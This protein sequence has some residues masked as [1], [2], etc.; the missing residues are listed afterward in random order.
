MDK[1]RITAAVRKWLVIV[2]IFCIVAVISEILR[3]MGIGND[4]IILVFILGVFFSVICTGSYL[5]GFISAIIGVGLFNYLYTVPRYT[6]F[7]SKSA[8]VFLLCFFFIT[9]TSIGAIMSKLQKQKDEVEKA[10]RDIEKEQLR[11]ALLRSIAHDL[12]SPLTAMYGTSEL[13]ADDFDQ[14][15]D[16][17]KIE[18]THGIRDESVWL[19]NI[20]EN[21]LRMTRI[22]ES[23][24]TVNKE[25]E[26]IDDIVETAVTHMKSLLGKREFSV[27]LP[28]EIVSV[29]VDGQLIA[30]V[31]INL[32]DNAV[33]YT[34]PGDHISLD[35]TCG[36]NEAFFSVSDDGKAIDKSVKENIFDSFITTAGENGDKCSGSGLGL[37]I[38]RTIVEAHGGRI[39]S[40]NIEPHGA[41]F[42]FSLPLE[43]DK[44]EK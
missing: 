25:D 44:N 23:R 39:Y 38:C 19:T 18:L 1:K 2:C 41:K 10:Q 11:N 7:I 31:I 36:E 13:L 35:V 26:V 43:D 42:T 21:T 12:R 22:N 20:V 29:P 8:D 4:T 24:M 15:S 6:L 40:E 17:E 27:S 3:N 9:V 32:L 33:K 34:E 37:A 14:L 28:Q 30:Q 5:C 16:K